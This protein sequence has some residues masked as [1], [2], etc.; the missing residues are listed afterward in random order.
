MLINQVFNIHKIWNHKIRKD[1]RNFQGDL[2]GEKKW[3]EV[4][5]TKW[6]LVIKIQWVMIYFL[7]K[8]ILGLIRRTIWFS[9]ISIV[10][11]RDNILKM[12]FVKRTKLSLFSASSVISD[13]QIWY[14]H[15]PFLCLPIGKGGMGWEH[16][17]SETVF[18]FLVR[19][20]SLK[21]HLALYPFDITDEDVLLY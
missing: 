8:M 14:R 10:A 16:L 12:G 7:Y 2:L 1:G 6:N 4:A 5:S 18:H 19:C 3:K 17:M 13:P 21:C 9:L 11:G 20:V 15:I